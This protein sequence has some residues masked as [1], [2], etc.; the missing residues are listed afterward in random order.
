MDL[1][2]NKGGNKKRGENGQNV[3][4]IKK[5]EYVHNGAIQERIQYI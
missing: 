4:K 3:Y 2:N 1:E 5:M